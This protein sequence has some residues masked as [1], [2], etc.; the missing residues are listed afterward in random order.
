MEKGREN[1]LMDAAHD[2]QASVAWRNA[3][4]YVT[5]FYF[6]VGF[7]PYI[8]LSSTY[9]GSA[10][11]AGSNLLN[12]L[13]AIILLISFV[14]FMAKER[15]SS[16]VFTPRLLMLAIFGWYIFTS[17]VGGAPVFSLRRLAM[18]A[19]ICVLASCFL[20]L[21]RTERH[22]TTLL[23]TC[24]LIILFLCYFGVAVLP[25][26]SIHQAS[27]ALE[28]L[29]AGNWRGVFRHKNEA[30]SIMAVLMIVGIYLC[31]RWSLIG[32][33]AVLLLS[34]IFL[35]KSGGK[36]ALGLMP[37]IIA[38]GW[39]IVGWPRWRY[40]VVTVL[41]G[42]FAVVIVG[43]TVDPVFSQMLM[44]LGIDASFTGRT[45]I[46]T[47]SIDYIRQSP[48]VGYGYQAFWRSDTLMTSFTENNTWA[49]TAPDSHNG[50]FDLVLGGGVP[51]LI[52]V[53][54]W[55]CLMP[56][57]DLGKMD[58][59]T[60]KSPLTKL[61]VGVWLYVL[62]YGFLETMFF[63]STGFVWF[64]LVVAVMG[65]RLQANASLVEDEAQAEPQLALTGSN[66]A[67][68]ARRI[69]GKSRR[70]LLADDILK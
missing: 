55:I 4:F 27:D 24:V 35:V 13:T 33:L 7:S 68:V 48:I 45:D 37:I 41:L 17:V 54:T 47:V 67:S 31:K 26:R 21:P 32:G 52:L 42:T 43:T 9:L 14:A 56:L 50:Y 44:K 15:S 3:L 34:L 66:A 8:S 70:S 1:Y 39:F 12:Q 5:F 16:I 23:A 2:E 49:T 40:A 57:R 65:L 19:I 20:Q 58:E 61:Y 18:C 29:L 62:L 60:R 59:A 69:R 63:L 25:S 28:P 38:T 30:A 6:T 53:L 10:M 11:A 51:G 36:T 64:F 22:F 46:W